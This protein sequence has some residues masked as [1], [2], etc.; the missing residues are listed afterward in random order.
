MEL[1]K[2]AVLGLVQG[3]T[4]FFPISSDGHLVTFG[5]WL[6]VSGE[7]SSAAFVSYLHVGTLLACCVAFRGEIAAMARLLLEP[8]RLMKPPAG[9]A[10]AAD[11]RFVVFGSA[12]TAIVA[13]PFLD[14]FEAAYESK[15]VVVA[16]M[17]LTGLLLLLSRW[18]IRLPGKD[19]DPMQPLLVGGAQ[20]L[21]ILPGLSRS[22]TT[23]VVGLIVGLPLA[24]V[25]A[26]S[27]LLSM[28]AVAGAV[29]MEFV[30]HPPSAALFGPIAVGIAVAFGVGL[31]A[32]RSMIVLVPR[33]RMHWFAPYMF[34]L[35]VIAALTL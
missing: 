7:G 20:T 11:A 23:V 19:A 21:A 3:L 28:P 4:E 33:G 32:V 8:R 27:F 12:A 6:G 15:P 13:L 1:W 35:A 29:A 14:L 25:A 31:F 34:A 18:A 24:R 17:V 5:R 22:C 10:V 2:A 16:C 9:D 26:L 30:R